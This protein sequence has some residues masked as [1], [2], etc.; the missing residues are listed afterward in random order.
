MAL[1]MRLWDEQDGRCSKTGWAF[2]LT[3]GAENTAKNPFTPCFDRIDSSG[4]YEPDNI[5]LVCCMYNL[6]KNDYSE[7]LMQEMCAAVVATAGN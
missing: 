6:A 4:K 5:Q 1:F 3:Q 7:E 2:S